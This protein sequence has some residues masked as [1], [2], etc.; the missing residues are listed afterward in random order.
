[1]RIGVSDANS[2][3]WIEKDFSLRSLCSGWVCQLWSLS[4]P[5]FP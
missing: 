3:L 1:M 5:F 2:E 4:F